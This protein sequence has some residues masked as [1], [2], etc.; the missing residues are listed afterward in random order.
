MQRQTQ[1]SHRLEFLD[2]AHHAGGGE[3]APSRQRPAEELLA[4]HHVMEAVL[5]AMEEEA[6]RLKGGAPLRSDFWANAIDFISTFVHGCHR[7]KESDCFFPAAVRAGLIDEG[8]AKGLEKEHRIAEDLTLHL[9]SRAAAGDW[10]GVIRVVSVYIYFMRPH[11]RREEDQL[12]QP[13][14]RS[15]AGEA[16]TSLLQAFRDVEKSAFQGRSRDDYLDLARQ[17]CR[18]AGV[19]HALATAG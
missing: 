4:E 10:E 19:G 16:E 6:N 12:M 2:W 5:A 8:Q 1:D 15:L 11:M 13:S 3:R 7:A 17:L 14:L 9:A 18:D